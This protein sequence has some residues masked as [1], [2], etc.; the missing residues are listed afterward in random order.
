MK[1]IGPYL[2]A[3]EAEAK[4]A[5]IT[6]DLESAPGEPLAPTAAD[7]PA[8][9]KNVIQPISKLERIPLEE[10]I[11]SFLRRGK[12]TRPNLLQA[13]IAIQIHEGW[14][15][16]T[17]INKLSA[18]SNT[19]NAEIKGLIDFYHFL[20][21]ER[22]K[23]YTLHV[24]QN[25]VDQ[26]QREGLDLSELEN[27]PLVNFKQTSCVGMC[28][29]QATILINGHPITHLNQERIAALKDV[30]NQRRPCDQWP[31]EW[32]QVDNR[33][34][35]TG[36]LLESEVFGDSAFAAARKLGRE[37]FLAQLEASGLRGRGGAGFPTHAKWKSCIEAPSQ[38]KFIVCNADE[39]EPGTFKDRFL[40]TDYLPHLIE[41]MSIAAWLTGAKQGYIYLRYEYLYLLDHINEKLN[42]YR[43]QGYLG[44]RPDKVFDFDI[45]VV[46]GAGA[47]ICGEESALLESI[48]GKRGIPRIRPPFP[49]THGLFGQPTIVNNVET[50]ATVAFI[51]QCGAD[52]YTQLGCEHSR[53]T[54]IHSMS[55]DCNEPG[56]YEFEY[57]TT[58][59]EMLDACAA[60]NPQ[61]V[62]IGGPA[63]KLIPAAEFDSTIDFDHVSSGGSFMIFGAD[64]DLTKITQNFLHFFSDES[65][66][67]CTPCRVGSQVLKQ[68]FDRLCEDKTSQHEIELM[69]QTAHLMQNTSH[70]GLGQTAANPWVHW[71]ALQSKPLQ[72]PDY[73]PIFDISDATAYTRSLR[74]T[75][76]ED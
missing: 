29:Q 2:Y 54:K 15:P 26:W 75:N 5:D 58:V 48:E 24:S 25:I 59:R 42:T 65:C 18:L 7:D 57:G 6:T 9:E 22:P 38:R 49:V 8:I 10:L 50:F 67:F 4:A 30:I 36:P 45:Q 21:C 63:G 28:D 43:Q 71:Q 3:P 41:G 32:F 37:E 69:Q 62:Q 70:C 17:A 11:D 73:I 56:F 76:S 35:K 68:H 60:I 27:H 74:T 39:G 72:A 23:A 34:G 51:A 46:L 33:I 61:A 55:G 47:Y 19:P 12:L 44:D 53:G 1:P 16:P 31:L 40:L 66:G 64:R 20:T 52:T 14:I 13:L